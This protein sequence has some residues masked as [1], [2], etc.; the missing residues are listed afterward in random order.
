MTMTTLD[1]NTHALIQAGRRALRSTAADRERIEASLR[2]RLGADALPLD[3]GVAQ[4]TRSITHSMGWHAAAGAA[5]GICVLAGVAF[6]ALRPTASDPLPQ[7][8]PATHRPAPQTAPAAPPRE[9]PAAVREPVAPAHAI[10]APSASPAGSAPLTRDHLAR[11]VALLS[12]ATSELRAGRAATALKVL[13]EHQRRFPSGVLI[14]ERRAAKA[15]ALCLVGRVREGR[16][17]LAQLT[18]QSPAAA[19]AQQVC[20]RAV[21]VAADRK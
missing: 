17:V 7:A 19:S 1:P 8:R 11:E 4:V 13:G 18:P 2:A 9:A 20:D 15:Q 3:S 16:A 5:I 21:S 6:V 12:R 10:V 14:E